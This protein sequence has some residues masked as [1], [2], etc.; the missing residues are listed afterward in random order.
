MK[1]TIAA[2]A[3]VAALTLTMAPAAQAAPHFG[4][5]W[6]SAWG[7]IVWVQGGGAF[8]MR[9]RCT[10]TAGNR[11]WHVSW[12]LSPH[13]YKWT[14]SDTGGWGDHRPRHLNCTFTRYE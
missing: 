12:L 13:E 7:F 11:S 5:R 14:T 6:T 1:R 3:I 4:R 2:V 10:W 9:S 8:Y